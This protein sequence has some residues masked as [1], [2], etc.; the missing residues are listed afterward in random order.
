M[1]QF[2][3]SLTDDASNVNYDRNMFIIQATGV[4]KFIAQSP[5]EFLKQMREVFFI[6]K[7]EFL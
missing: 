5:E 3:A 6:E 2:G 7:F 1:L 4:K